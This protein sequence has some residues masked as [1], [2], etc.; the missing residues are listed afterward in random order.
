MS[1]DNTPATTGHRSRVITR[2]QT[3]EG[4]NRRTDP[5]NASHVP[6]TDGRLCDGQ[7]NPTATPFVSSQSP[8]G[9]KSPDR[10][11]YTG[12]VNR[13][14]LNLISTPLYYPG[15]AESR[16]ENRYEMEGVVPLLQDEPISSRPKYCVA[17]KVET[18]SPSG[19]KHPTNPAY[20]KPN[21]IKD[22]VYGPCTVAGTL[23]AEAIPYTDRDVMLFFGNKRRGEGLTRD[24]ADEVTRALKAY[25]EPWAT[26]DSVQFDAYTTLVSVGKARIAETKVKINRNREPNR[27]TGQDNQPHACRVGT[28]HR[29]GMTGRPITG[30]QE[31]PNERAQLME[32]ADESDE[33]YRSTSTPASRRR[34]TRPR[35]SSSDLILEKL[36][37]AL[38]G[39]RQGNGRLQGYKLPKFG[40]ESDTTSDY[41]DWRVQVDGITDMGCSDEE[42]MKQ[43]WR[44]LKGEPARIFSRTKPKTLENV[45]YRLEQFM[46]CTK[47]Y[48][49][50]CDDLTRLVQRPHEDITKFAMRVDTEVRTVQHKFPTERT[51]EGYAALAKERLIT[52]MSVR[53]QT[54]LSYMIDRAGGEDVTFDQILD[55]AKRIETR[56]EQAKSRSA[57]FKKEEPAKPFKSRTPLARAAAVDQMVGDPDLS[58]ES[59]DDSEEE[60]EEN[61]TETAEVRPATA[62]DTCR[63]CKKLGHW[64]RD[65]PDKPKDKFKKYHSCCNPT[66]PHQKNKYPKVP[67]NGE[68]GVSK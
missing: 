49:H 61:D 52:G 50:M 68:Q 4:R 48:T 20:W 18:L 55:A 60:P 66:C 5:L 67:L 7:L 59:A 42:I 6:G 36:T 26:G 31:T 35:K 8:S 24:Q 25:D 3:A 30:H 51:E 43:I 45:L 28:Q 41:A 47:S 32:T 11:G 39:N 1:D 63:N 10:P 17:L 9:S 46:G 19:N 33:E 54:A 58:E 37:E 23:V 53:N 62:T 40:G 16:Y 12:A 56:Q 57:V 14:I 65:C 38:T 21:I 13:D 2:S 34:G 29:G 44:S 15:A 64:A 27:H 22:M